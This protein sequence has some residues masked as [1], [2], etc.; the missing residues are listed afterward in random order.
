MKQLIKRVLFHAH[1]DR[2]PL[3]FRNAE[4]HRQFDFTLAPGRRHAPGV[5]AMLRIKNEATKIER[6]I[7]SI[8]DLFDE[9]I[10][11]NNGSTDDTRA[12]VEGLIASGRCPGVR[13]FDYPFVLSRCGAENADTA[14]DSVHSLT[15]YSNWSISHCSRRWVF[16]WDGDMFLPSAMR[17]PMRRALARIRTGGLKLWNVKGQTVYI[18]RSGQAWAARGE[19]NQEEMCFPNSPFVHFQKQQLWERL[20]TPFY[21]EEDCPPEVLFLEIKDTREDEFAHW[22]DT[23]SFSPRKLTEYRNY[24]TV[25]DS[26]E[27]P[28]DAFERIELL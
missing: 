13:L 14:G 26:T 3:D 15:Y 11:V 25:R 4:G 7:L 22:T 2:R 10:V 12:L 9:V 27:P 23:S 1:Y 24:I 19:V 6:C 17:E 16:K 5:S 18:D 8:H 28:A 20:T 21:L